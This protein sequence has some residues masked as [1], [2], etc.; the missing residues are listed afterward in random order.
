MDNRLEELER[1][2]ERWRIVYSRYNPASEMLYDIREA[3][4]DMNWLIH[5]VRRLREENGQLREFIDELRRQMEDE[6]S[7]QNRSKKKNR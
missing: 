6:L 2:L 7:P 3:G 5:E 4:D 1:R